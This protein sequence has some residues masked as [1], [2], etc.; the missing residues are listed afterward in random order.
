ML[1]EIAI[2]LSKYRIDKAYVLLSQSELL[3]KN[4]KYAGSINRS[5]YAVFNAIRS[6]LAQL[7]LDSS[8]HVGVLSF[9][10]RYFVKTGFFNKEF[11]KIALAVFDSR[12]DYDYEDFHVPTK[13]QAQRQLEDARLFINEAENKRQSIINGEIDLPKTD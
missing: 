7:K 13:E 9:F 3:F 2:D 12:P 4:E 10:D 5:Y 11:S 6:L 8:S 1:D